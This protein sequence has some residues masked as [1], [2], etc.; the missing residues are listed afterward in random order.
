MSRTVHC[1]VLKKEAAGLQSPPWPGE[2]GRRVFE[3]VSAEAWSR[4][5]AHQTM[6]INEKRLSLVKAEHKSYLAAQ[7]EKFFFGGEV[8]QPAGYV[9]ADENK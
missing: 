5:L 2:L 4:W 8:D 1:V 6:L 3:N 7:M 9:A